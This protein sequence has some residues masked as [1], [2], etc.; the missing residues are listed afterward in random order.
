MKRI[1]VLCTNPGAALGVGVAEPTVTPALGA[2]NALKPFTYVALGDS[3]PSG[4]RC[5]LVRT[6]VGLYADALAKKT[7]RKIRFSNLAQATIP[8]TERG[9]TLKSLLSDLRSDPKTRRAVAAAD[10]IVVYSSGANDLG[11]T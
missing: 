4:A 9:Q 6:F 2:G 3:W 10:I 1:L 11:Q 5:G 7:G 8:G